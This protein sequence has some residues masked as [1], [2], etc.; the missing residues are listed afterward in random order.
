MDKF[1]DWTYICNIF[2]IQKYLL[3][4]VHVLSVSLLPPESL[5]TPAILDILWWKHQLIFIISWVLLQRTLHFIFV[6]I[7]PCRISSTS[8]F[9]VLQQQ[10]FLWQILFVSIVLNWRGFR[11]GH[12]YHL[13]L[14]HDPIDQ[15]INEI[16][17]VANAT[18]IGGCG[19]HRTLWSISI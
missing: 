11:F 9:K 12:G 17:D 1:W 19:L 15:K 10:P 2:F 16:D 5:I 3:C 18:A 13:R 4:I 14:L 8:F 7:E 6:D